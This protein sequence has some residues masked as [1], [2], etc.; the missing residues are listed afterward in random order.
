MKF[1]VKIILI[2]CFISIFVSCKKDPEV[3][4]YD[5]NIISLA[6]PK[7]FPLPKFPSDNQ[8]TEA[9]I[10]LGKKLF[11]DPILSRDFTISCKT[12]H[13]KN[14]AFSDQQKLSAGIENRKGIR[15]TPGLFNIAYNKSFFWDGGV[16]TLEQQ[17]LAPIENP[18]EMDFNVSDAVERLEKD[19]EYRK[20][21]RKA[22]NQEPSIYSLTRAIAN[23]ERTLLSGNSRFDDYQQNKNMN[24]LNESEKNGMEI[25]FGEKGECFHCH[26]GFNFTDN[27]FMN[28]GLYENY[29][30]SGRQRVTQNEEDKG[31]FKVPS[32]RNINLTPP[33]MHDGSLATLEEVID[34][35][36]SGGKNNINKS[37]F[38][39]PLGLSEGEKKDIVNF[40]KSLTEK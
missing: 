3:E 26:S 15:N 5:E 13:L 31:K 20:L 1:Q 36:N 24:A 10:L 34:H 9:R 12:C 40:L 29:A 30:D 38:I 22:Y 16:P 27:S 19:E 2:L 11:E 14:M 25:F 39:K 28:N 32:L 17:V 35:Y 8:P 18:L 23:Y 37:F 4:L 33:Y 7:G 21:F 6:I